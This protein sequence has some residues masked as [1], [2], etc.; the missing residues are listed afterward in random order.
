M[1]K[2]PAIVTDN[3]ANMVRAVVMMGLTQ[4]GCF[5]HIINLASQAGLKLPKYCTPAWRSKTHRKVLS[6]QYDSHPHPQRKAEATAA[7]STQAHN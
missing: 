6:S 5:A 1:R 2:G 4:G 7:E 3:V